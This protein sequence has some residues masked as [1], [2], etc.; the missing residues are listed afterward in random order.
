MYS[1]GQGVNEDDSK[2]LMYFRKAL[3]NGDETALKN[4]DMLEAKLDKR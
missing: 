3:K 1:H 2:A 4:H